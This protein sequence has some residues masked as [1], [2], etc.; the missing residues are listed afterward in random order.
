MDP[1]G[2][3]LQSLKTEKGNWGLAR[4]PRA[5]PW[6][7]RQ[8]GEKGLPTNDRQPDRQ[9][10]KPG[11][12]DGTRAV[13]E[14]ENR[15]KDGAG[16]GLRLQQMSA[17]EERARTLP[18]NPDS[19]TL[20]ELDTPPPTA[21]AAETEAMPT[22]M[23]ADRGEAE[24]E[25]MQ[26]GVEAHKR[27]EAEARIESGEAGRVEIAAVQE[28]SEP[29]PLLQHGYEGDEDT[30]EP[31]KKR[32]KVV[33]IEDNGQSEAQGGMMQEAGEQHLVKPHDQPSPTGELSSGDTPTPALS[34]KKKASSS[35]APSKKVALPSKKAKSSSK[36][37]SSDQGSKKKKVKRDEA[38][39]AAVAVDADASTTVVDE[40]QSSYEP[41]SEGDEKLYCIC[42]TLYG[43]FPWM[44]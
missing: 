26:D 38:E 30:P 24:A 4:A 28:S 8:T 21:A 3:D 19:K 32:A 23:E 13:M 31:L 10:N 22:A 27:A 7:S 20:P 40:M 36:K 17:Q 25:S 29:H 2:S 11:R 18:V 37:K 14:G 44:A 43:A 35:R 42:Q 6:I 9:T 34:N 33:K 39:D 41:E 15:L 16:S 12:K 1:R 5:L